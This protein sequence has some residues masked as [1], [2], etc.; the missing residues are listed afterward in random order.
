[1]FATAY[2]AA[3]LLGW[4]LESASIVALVGG[5]PLIVKGGIKTLLAFPFAFHAINGVRHLVYDFGVGFTK[6]QV[7]KGGYYILG[8][9]VLSSLYLAF[10]V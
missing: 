2:L 5:L 4:H 1:M 6:G 9:S 8:A 3:P 7:T 10:F